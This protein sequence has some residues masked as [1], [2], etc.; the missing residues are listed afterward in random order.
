MDEIIKKYEDRLK[1]YND[2]MEQIRDIATPSELGTFKENSLLL[3]EVI[4][5]LK[6]IKINQLIK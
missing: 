3:I 6:N 2:A 1:F 5:D 4:D